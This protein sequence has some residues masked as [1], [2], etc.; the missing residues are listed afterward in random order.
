MPALSLP[1][2]EDV[3]EEVLRTEIIT[4]ARSPMDGKTLS[5]AEYV[6]LQERLQ[7]ASPNSQLSPAVRDV[8]FQLRIRQLLR[9]IGIPIR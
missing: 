1:P 2:P 6:Q 9:K 7:A 4:E 3:P 5:P 8:I